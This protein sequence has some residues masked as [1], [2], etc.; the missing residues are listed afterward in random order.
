LKDFLWEVGGEVFEVDA[1]DRVLET[2]FTEGQSFVL[3]ENGLFLFGEGPGLILG[4][5]TR[6]E[7]LGFKKLA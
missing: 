1:I 6:I 5:E 7:H 2:F 3:I 4:S